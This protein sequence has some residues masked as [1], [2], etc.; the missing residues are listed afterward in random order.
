VER[1]IDVMFKAGSARVLALIAGIIAL[2]ATADWYVGTRASLGVFY[3]V[4]MVIGATVLPRPGIIVVAIVCS[5]L[6]SLFDLPSPPHIEELL[7]F[8]FAALAYASSGMLVAALIRN[9]ELTITNLANL[10]REQELRREAEEQLRILVESSPAAILTVD[11]GGIVLAANRATNTLFAIPEI[12]TMKG[13]AIGSYLPVLADAL[14][15]DPGPEGLRTAAQS[16]GRKENGE[17]FLAN[18]W[19]SSYKTPEGPRLAAIIVDSSEE[20]R[21]REEQSFRQL[22]E[23]NRIAAAAVFHEVRNLCGAITVISSNLKEKHVITQDEDIQA[24][25]SIAGGLERIV[26]VE[27]RSRTGN[28]LEEVTLGNV[29]DDLRIVI[30]QDWREIDGAVFWHIPETIPKVLADGHGLLQAFLNLAHNSHRA[31]QASPVHDPPWREL[32]IVVSVQEHKVTVRFLD[33]GPGVEAPEKLFAPFQPGANGTGLGLYVSR[34]VVRSY[35]GDLR[36]EP[37][38]SGACFVVELQIA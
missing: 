8:V 31:V 34:A 1:V 30:E 12:G 9:R 17:V 19:F 20:M 2:I 11:G 33:S 3:I 22:S 36:F 35:G 7:R 15:F 13:R 5:F 21:E 23:G 24:L 27:L 25:T 38:A 6:R 4:P 14:Q 28:T 29:L 37:Q 10:R 18:A 26:A 16:Q 32:S